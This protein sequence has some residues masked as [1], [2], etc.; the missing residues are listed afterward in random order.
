MIRRLIRILSLYASLPR[1]YKLAKM[2]TA[3]LIATHHANYYYDL[4]HKIR[5][6]RHKYSYQI[7]V[8]HKDDGCTKQERYQLIGR[9]IKKFT[10]LNPYAESPRY[11]YAKWDYLDFKVI[12]DKN[13]VTIYRN[14]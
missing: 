4:E 9:E 6:K 7:I 10:K 13:I 1:V 5:I 8:T 2:M 12:L 14:I 11:M 3:S